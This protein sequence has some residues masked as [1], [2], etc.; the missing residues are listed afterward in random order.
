VE[1]RQALKITQEFHSI[2]IVGKV[3]DVWHLG[4]AEFYFAGDFLAGN[5]ALD[6]FFLGG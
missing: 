3:I 1:R 4:F 2:N 6:L 5:N